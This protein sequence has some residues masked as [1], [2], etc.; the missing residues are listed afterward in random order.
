[1]FHRHVRRLDIDEQAKLT[2]L[3]ADAEIDV[4]MTLER[5]RITRAEARRDRNRD[6]EL[7]VRQTTFFD[8]DENRW[9]NSVRGVIIDRLERAGWAQ[10]GGLRHGD[11]IQRIDE[12]EIRGLKS[13]RAAMKAITEKESERVVFVVLRGVRTRFQYVEPDWGPGDDSGGSTEV[14][15]KE[16]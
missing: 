4:S 13:Y 1:M 11:L 3:R 16:E 7:I 15:D 8:R 12:F 9:D 14:E 5:T 6:F 10:L 2:V